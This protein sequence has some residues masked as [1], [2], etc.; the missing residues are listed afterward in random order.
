MDAAQH[1][2]GAVKSLLLRFAIIL[3]L[4]EEYQA[5]SPTSH[6]QKRSQIKLCNEFSLQKSFQPSMF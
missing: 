5:L 3:S 2:P 1:F 4:H 6:L